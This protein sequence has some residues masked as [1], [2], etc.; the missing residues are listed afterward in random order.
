MVRRFLTAMVLLTAFGAPASAELCTI[1][2]VPAATILVP[3]FEVD[4]RNFG[5]SKF[6]R[7]RVTLINT[8]P[9]PT[10]AHVI[11]WSDLSA[12]TFNFD[13][14]LTGF[15]VQEFDV[16]LLFTNGVL[17][18]PEIPNVLG[19][20]SSECTRCTDGEGCVN[21]SP[22]NDFTLADLRN[23]HL[24]NPVDFHNGQCQGRRIGSGNVARGYIT[25][26]AVSAC[27]RLFPGDSGYFE[28]GGTGIATN[29]N[30]L[31]A[32]ITTYSSKFL[33]EVPA[34]HV[35]AG[36]SDGLSTDGNFTFYGRY[37]DFDASDNRECG[38]YAW[39]FPFKRENKFKTEAIVW[40]DSGM[41]Q[42]PFDC[43]EDPSWFPLD[44]TQ[45][46]AFNDQEDFRELEGFPF[47]AETQIV[48]VG[49]NPLNTSPF[50]TGWVFVSLADDSG[51]ETV[52]HGY[53]NVRQRFKSREGEAWAH[54]TASICGEQ[55]PAALRA[56]A[57]ASRMGKS[58]AGNG[59]GQK[60]KKLGDVANT[61]PRRRSE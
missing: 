55:V 13:I 11:L 10:L 28:N 24:G 43:S 39:M 36:T 19:F 45:I 17:P 16:D 42:G 46:V 37:V 20:D 48:D 15:D 50:K 4:F 18:I 32:T 34:I 12:P 35:E 2:A 14:F 7:T 23:A 54:H 6:E 57:R 47:P 27:T 44:T 61:A 26:D 41:S 59:I 30:V 3:Y 38:G 40:R 33:R 8:A 56:R 31:K 1:D 49:K 21:F 60:R 58:S 5:K 22:S 9:E 25:I 52:G 29:N 53:V 51:D